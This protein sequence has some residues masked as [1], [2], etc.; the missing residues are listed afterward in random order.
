MLRFIALAFSCAAALTAA[1]SITA[2]YNAASYAPPSL[3]NS[4]IA[5]GSIFTLFGATL[6]PNVAQSASTY[7]LATTQGLGGTTVQ[8]TVSGV[9]KNCVMLYASNPQVNVILP[10]S[11]P[12]GT[13]TLTVSYQGGN[14][15][16][17]IQVLP[18]NFGA[19]TLNSAGS[20]PAV[21]TDASYVPITMVNAAHPGQTLILW[22]TG[23]GPITASETVPPPEVDLGSGVQVFVEN[24]SAQVMYGGRSSSPGLDQ[25]NFVVPAGAEGCKVSIAVVVKGV[26]GNVTTMS[27]APAGQTTCGD[28]F[29]PLTTKNLQK[30]LATGTLGLGAVDLYRVGD[31]SAMFVAGF[32]SYPVNTLIRSF[33][34]SI[35]PSIGSC[36]AYEVFG[37][38]F[39]VVD[40]YQPMY[41]DAGR[42]LTI[43]APGGDETIPVLASGA[44]SSALLNQP[45]TYVQP[46]SYTVSNG[47]GGVQ[48]PPFTRNLTLP[49]NVAPTNIP[50]S[51]N[52]SQDLTLT[53]SGGQA[54]PVVTIFGYAGVPVSSTLNS[55]AEFICNAAGSAGTFTIPAAILKVIPPNGYGSFGVPG[56]N[57]Q[58]AGIS[59]SSFNL[60][61]VDEGFFNVYV[62]N[63]SVA[64]IQ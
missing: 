56:V 39:G 36:T 4:G 28:Q 11:T 33:A 13:G 34:G 7:P 54:F 18:A 60:S 17:A 3:P 38:S 48:I 31:S 29:G 26:T 52:L 25:I 16:I 23:L 27:V 41:L 64:K 5:Q 1:P 51:I 35:G 30:A 63:G 10:S 24:Q 61:G 57:I 53:W 49:E 32:G 46:G 47:S 40:P 43:T 37:A 42:Q 55:Y 8:V 62:S 9:T 50:S 59:S 58:L 14:G 21:V 6:G 22:G 20:G 45:S 19:V 15:S 2:I 44:F 12:V